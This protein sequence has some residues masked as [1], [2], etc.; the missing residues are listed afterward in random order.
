MLPQDDPTV[1]QLPRSYI[2]KNERKDI[3]HS[4]NCI[5]STKELTDNCI[6]LLNQYCLIRSVINHNELDYYFDYC[7]F[8]LACQQRNIFVCSI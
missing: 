4:K 3:S 7:F 6:S 5:P 1:P 2:V 8:Y